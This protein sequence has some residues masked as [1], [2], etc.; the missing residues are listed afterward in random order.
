M[1]LFISFL[2]HVNGTDSDEMSGSTASW[3]QQTA[4]K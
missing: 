4:N 1:M 2:Q 3:S